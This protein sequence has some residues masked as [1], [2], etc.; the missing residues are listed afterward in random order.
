MKIIKNLHSN[1]CKRLSKFLDMKSPVDREILDQ[2]KAGKLT[3]AVV[4]LQTWECEICGATNDNKNKY[5][6]FCERQR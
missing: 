6:W 4:D 3:V 2:I 1:N 5:C